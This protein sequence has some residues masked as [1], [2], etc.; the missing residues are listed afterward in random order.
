MDAGFFVVCLGRFCRRLREAALFVAV[1]CLLLLA[2]VETR[3][4]FFVHLAFGKPA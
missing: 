1:V 2:G 3:S 4:L